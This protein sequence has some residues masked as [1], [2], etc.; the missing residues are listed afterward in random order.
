[1][2]KW[3]IE[4]KPKNNLF[5]IDFKALWVYRDLIRMFVYRDFVTYYKQ[6]I[7]G[8]IWFFIQPIFTAIINLFIF[9]KMAGVGPEGIP[10]FLF[11]LSGPILWQYFQDTFTKT[12]STFV[13][14]QH[15][16][17][18]VYFPR[19]I[20]PITIVISGLLKF[21]VQLSLL[22][23]GIFIYYFNTDALTIR[24]EIVFFPLLL[25][26]VI[27]LSL[28]FG[29]IVSALTTKYRDLKFLIDFAVPLFK[30]VTPGIATTYA[31]FTDKL[32]KSLTVFVKYN[33]LG[34]I[35]D[36][37]NFMF[38]G[39]GSFQVFNLL[40]SALFALVV[41]FIGLI[42]FNQTDKTFMDTV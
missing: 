24:W 12:S 35:I 32:P 31:I 39:A 33:P 37:F 26:I 2:N 42:I 28:G 17:G 41:L 6:T 40:Y 14:N 5:E 38:V 29:L 13:E 25:L 36:S 9:G 1:M 20:M 34:Y 18:K 21:F 15:I 16:F 8:P 10:G 27:I 3:D 11:Y 23:I 7:L 22:L 19:L 4:I 30:Y